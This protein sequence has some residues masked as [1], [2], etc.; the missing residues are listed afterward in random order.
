MPTY[1]CTAAKGLLN[2][3]QKARIAEAITAAHADITGA[4]A[5]F[6]QVYFQEIAE[7]DHFIGGRP[8]NHEHVF[9]YGHIRDGRAAVDRKALI[10]KMTADLAEIVELPTFSI[11]VYLAE[12]PAA[13][14]V[15]FG[16][17]LPEAG[18]APIWNDALPVE[19]R[20]RMQAISK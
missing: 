16:H 13:S 8:L 4:P 18:D 1:T 9:V 10:R 14:M 3:D 15:E 11:W 12:L 5:Y 2:Q 19:D 17:I 6:A 7:G 20:E